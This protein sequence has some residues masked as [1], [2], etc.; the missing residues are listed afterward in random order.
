MS[1]GDAA[2][3]QT[4]ES[5]TLEGRLAEKDRTRADQAALLGT[6]LAAVVA[7]SFGPGSWGWWSVGV[8]A[9]LLLVIFAFY[10]VPDKDINVWTRVREIL[11]LA[12][13]AGYCST[14]LLGYP[15][16]TWWKHQGGDSF[17]N[18]VANA[19]AAKVYKEVSDI[20]PPN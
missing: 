20:K 15:L 14:I 6:G 16:Q 5:R 9:T 3:R 2:V 4:L 13:V 12:A 19:A 8:G 17:C 7:V 18:N 10:R 1:E 11:A